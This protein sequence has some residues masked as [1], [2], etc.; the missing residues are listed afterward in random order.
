MTITLVNEGSDVKGVTLTIVP[1]SLII[2]KNDYKRVIYESSIIKNGGV[3]ETYQLH[4]D[5]RAVSGVYGI[6][7]RARWLSNDQQRE[8]NQTFNV[9]VRG[10][11]QLA[12]SNITVNP[13][14]ISPKDMF[15]I[16]GI[17]KRI[18]SLRIL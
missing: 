7:F 11:P 17:L 4:V 3:T 12:I 2:L 14:L 18:Y 13:E 10:V 8:T 9:M 15:N 1:D 6:E 5:P 16:T